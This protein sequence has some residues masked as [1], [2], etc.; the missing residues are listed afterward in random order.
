MPA[1]DPA[2]LRGAVVIERDRDRRCHPARGRRQ[3]FEVWTACWN[4]PRRL[5]RD[6]ATGVEGD[7]MAR[8]RRLEFVGKAKARGGRVSR[9]GA[10]SVAA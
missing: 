3:S 8:R 9:S 4:L 7:R 2:D 10:L 5:S 1:D 6:P